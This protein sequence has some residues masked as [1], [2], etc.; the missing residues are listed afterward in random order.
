MGAHCSR[1]TNGGFLF[2]DFVLRGHPCAMIESGMGFVRAELATCTLLSS[3]RPRLVVSVGIAGA[4]EEGPRVGDVVVASAACLLESG[5]PGSR[6]QLQMPPDAALAAAR[7]ALKARGAG[8]HVGTAVTTRGSQQIAGDHAELPCPVL[9]ME[10]VGIAAACT[11]A[12]IG[13]L[14]VRGISDTPADP[15][16]VPID[17]LVDRNFNLRRGGLILAILKRPSLLPRLI[18]FGSQGEMAATNAAIATVAMMPFM[19]S[20]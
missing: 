11:S 17:R 5:V 7:A 2:Y 1:R 12:G 20:D 4:A 13:L 3:L 10:T 14:S 18:R 9:E 8:L 19:D 15:S 16:P 6:E